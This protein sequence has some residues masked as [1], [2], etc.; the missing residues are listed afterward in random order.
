M[1]GESAR[2]GVTV[3]VVELVPVPPGV[4]TAIGPVEAVAGTVAVT[5]R[6][7]FTVNVAA[8]PPLN[9]TDVAPVNPEPLITTF[10]PTVPLVGLNDEIVGP[11]AT[12]LG[13]D[14][15]NVP[16]HNPRTSSAERTRV[17]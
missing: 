2:P 6:S 14:I 7:E 17:M 1:A 12:E 15:R 11:A 3:K 9:V 5:L 8:A 13:L 4:V 10:V 16:A